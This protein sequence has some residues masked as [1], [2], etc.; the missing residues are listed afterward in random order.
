MA[1]HSWATDDQQKFLR[2]QLDD[3]FVAQKAGKLSKFWPK[4]QKQW[5]EQWP[6]PGME[7]YPSDEPVGNLSASI[8]VQNKR[9][10]N[11]FY[12]N[13]ENNRNR[14]L[15]PTP[16]IL[17][18]KQKRTPSAVQLY[19]TEKYT[20]TIKSDVMSEI[21]DN[22]VPKDKM[23]QVV[24][25]Q[26]AEK[27]RA[28][29]LEVQTHYKEKSKRLRE[30]RLE[31]KKAAMSVS[32]PTP[33]SYDREIKNL[34][35]T[36]EALL[37]DLNKRTGWSFL[38]LAGGPD[39]VSGKIRTL[40]FNEGENIVG[41][42][43][44]KCHPAFENDYIKPFF[45]FLKQAYPPAIRE[46][47]RLVAA[48]GN[49][50]AVASGSIHT[51]EVYNPSAATSVR[52]AMP[53]GVVYSSISISGNPNSTEDGM[54][55]DSGDEQPD[56]ADDRNPVDGP[57]IGDCDSM[58][59]GYNENARDHGSTRGGDGESTRGGDDENARGGDVTVE[60]ARG[61]D[62]ESAR[63]NNGVNK[64]WLDPSL[65]SSPTNNAVGAALPSQSTSNSGP[66][67]EGEGPP[68]TAMSHENA[69]C[70]PEGSAIQRNTNTSRIQRTRQA[71]APKVPITLGDKHS[72]WLKNSYKCLLNDNCS[73]MWSETVEAWL[74]FEND[75]PLV[76]LSSKRL[77]AIKYRPAEL[78]QWLGKR[79]F[80]C[81]PQIPD[82]SAYAE[83][84]KTWWANMKTTTG[85]TQS[86][87]T[88]QHLRIGG[89]NGIV[90][91]LFGLQW[92][93]LN[94][95]QDVA[96]WNAIMEEI[97]R[98]FQVSAGNAM[99]RKSDTRSNKNG[100]RQKRG[101]R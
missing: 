89:P 32:E 78:S 33:A 46:A 76:N 5:Y 1:P 17:N 79:D 26:T 40:S 55:I 24:L 36:I 47:R 98:I 97:C 70:H 44:A 52:D 37:L 43:F 80:T 11:W 59:G 4:I 18:V 85:K 38:V 49:T 65:R 67:N 13:R 29:P 14:G 8:Q 61:R 90:T 53:A 94:L 58:R 86:S 77:P 45:N 48:D 9:L 73:T 57:V 27:F 25:R 19:S 12:N 6:E 62:D 74:Q 100:K 64:N 96:Q 91:L 10:Q 75:L 101:T 28:E 20:T 81:P 54:G 3:F 95:S 66:C 42:T 63:A 7:G 35:P 71:A 16:I 92:W 39:P 41:H 34:T 31:D 68:V 60:S 88:L 51:D 22:S 2:S 30:Q 83:N 23:L 56:P 72:E 93:Q 50:P 84:M 15:R 82:I 69:P 99:K 21:Q 87:G